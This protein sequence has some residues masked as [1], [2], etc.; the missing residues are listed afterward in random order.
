MSQDERLQTLTALLAEMDGFGD[1][2]GI[3]VIAATNQPEVLDPALLRP[4]R[5]D[6]KVFIPL[7]GN[8]DRKEILEYYLA[9]V[10]TRDIDVSA[11]AKQALGFSGADIANWVNEAAVEAARAGADVVQQVHFQLSRDRI[12]L[13]P[14]NHG[15]TLSDSDKDVTAWHE[16]GHAIA[17]IA[18]GGTVDKVSILPRGMAMGVTI[19]LP[20]DDTVFYTEKR[21]QSELVVLMAGRAAEELFVG[22][23]S[24]GAASDMARASELARAGV[25]SYGF[26]PMGPFVPKSDKLV[27]EAE[28]YAANWVRDAYAQAKSTL[29]AR[30]SEVTALR[31]RLLA[32]EEVTY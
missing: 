11:L 12:L 7:P 15:V 27:A 9:K 21:L 22:E 28:T 13:G 16:A 5:F 17:R 18:T 2:T 32:E 1:N 8:S 25:M 24:A 26:S 3:L 4:G 19:S 6:R 31:D 14:R 10:P 30:T 29:V 23:I 20:D